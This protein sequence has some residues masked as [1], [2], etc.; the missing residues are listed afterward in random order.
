MS[1]LPADAIRKNG[2]EHI[3]MFMA[4]VLQKRASRFQANH[5]LSS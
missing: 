1:D 3:G 2:Q 4:V 5:R